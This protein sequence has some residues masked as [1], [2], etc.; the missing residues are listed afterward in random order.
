MNDIGYIY[1][2]ELG[3]PKDKDSVNKKF[4]ESVEFFNEVTGV[5][6][7]QPAPQQETPV[8]TPVESP[9]EKPAEEPKQES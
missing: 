3:R 8:E 1:S 6:K 9:A 5:I 2:S 4:M 7:E